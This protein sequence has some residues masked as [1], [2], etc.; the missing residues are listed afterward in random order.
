MKKLTFK[1]AFF[2]AG[3]TAIGS[4]V[5]TLC[6]VG[7]RFTGFGAGFAYMIAG[8]LI[9]FA[10][11]PLLALGSFFPR[12]GGSYT[13]IKECLNPYI[14]AIYLVIFM[15][16]K[17]GLA[18]FAVSM[19][20]YLLTGVFGISV[21]RLVLRIVG[22]VI[23]TLFYILN[24][25]GQGAA[26]K[27]QNWMTLVLLI[28]LVSFAI[29]G[30]FRV[31]FSG[32]FTS[33]NIFPNGSSGFTSALCVLVF[34]VIGGIG[35][36]DYGTNIEN[37][38]RNIPKIAFILIIG[39][40]ILNGVIAF[41]AALAAELTSPPAHLLYAANAIGGPI[42][43]R[44]FVLCGAVL[45]LAS[46]INGNFPWVSTVLSRGID[47][48]LVP[49]ALGKT[50]KHGAKYILFTILYVVAVI[51]LLLDMET[52]LLANV[53]T[54]LSLLF[55]IIPNI[56]LIFAP[57]KYKDEWDQTKLP[58]SRALIA[59]WAILATAVGLFLVLRSILNYTTPTKI[60]L[61]CVFVLGIIYA[62][63]MG[64]KLTKEKKNA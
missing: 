13:Y 18:M 59:V 32:Q 28:A 24:L 8:L 39:T 17:I 56:A 6:G 52:A 43:Q 22:F 5:I 47:D 33:Q 4:G 30:L 14:G 38:K 48:G 37:P 63:V 29:I 51:I 40:A 2:M 34:G 64:K 11:S 44:I 49:A 16:A 61:G 31:D 25:Q 35:V 1:D 20:E 58:K 23:I 27:M 55:T 9:C 21:N 19:A 60:V 62:I 53:A 54:G 46:T 42:Y 50:N 3:G 10:V 12:N 36:V 41:V 26:V 45:A 7:I 15:V 57:V